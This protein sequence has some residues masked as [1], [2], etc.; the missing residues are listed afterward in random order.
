MLRSFKQPLGTVNESSGFALD[1]SV[2]DAS[3][4]AS[5]PTTLEWRLVCASTDT[6][7]Q[8]WATI[9]PTLSYDA[10]G[11]VIAVTAALT[12]PGPLNALQTGADQEQKAVI[13]V[14][15]RGLSTEWSA[16]G[17]YFVVRLEAR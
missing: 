12:V 11:A 13:V 6:T 15:D 3:G 4:A 16:E 2:L 1:V 9:T 7:L 5:Q 17:Q 14:A 8:D 10:N